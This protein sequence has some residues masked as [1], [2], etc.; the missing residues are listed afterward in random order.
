MIPKD[1]WKPVDIKPLF[2]KEKLVMISIFLH[3]LQTFLKYTDIRNKTF[4][5]SGAQLG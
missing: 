3:K 4:Q 1:V 5:G 2:G